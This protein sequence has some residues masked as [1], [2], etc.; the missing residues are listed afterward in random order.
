LTELENIFKD[1]EVLITGGT[2]SIGREIVK[3]VL[4][5]K[6]RGIRVFDTNENAQF[7]FRHEM[8]DQKRLRY[9]IGDTR[10]KERLIMALE[11][12][13]IVYHLAGLK[14]VIACEY[15][16]FEAVKTNVIGTQNLIEAVFKE[17]SVEK[18]IFSSSDKAVNPGNVMGTTKLLAEKLI[19]AANFYKGNRE[20]VFSSV[21]FGNVIGSMGSVI[22]LFH[23]QIKAG[24]PV[25]VTDPN[26]TRYI[27]SLKHS[28]NL[29]FKTTSI[30]RGGE[31]FIFK[32]RAVN[33][34]VLAQV[35]VEHLQNKHGYGAEDMKI[36]IIGTKAGEKM[37]EEL[38]TSEELKRAFETPEML[39][40]LPSIKELIRTEQRVSDYPEAMEAKSKT[41]DSKQERTLTKNEIK[42]WL[43]NEKIL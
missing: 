26:M 6:P 27:L 35:M 19:T 3:A 39:I 34:M 16:P 24:G 7:E 25:T 20:T 38:V 40:V 33:I 37:S 28:I 18:V 2:G 4:E 13:D 31:V 21:R 10:D 36:E 12:V 41:Y 15:N 30:A 32:M 29:L 17:G 1:K 9:F 14:H 8:G 11:N 5:F 23:N 43:I 42:K 22:P